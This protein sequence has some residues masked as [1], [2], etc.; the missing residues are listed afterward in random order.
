MTF[1]ERE[2]RDQVALIRL[3]RSV[4]NP[5]NL[6]LINELS[7]YII[8]T[9]SDRETAGV[10]LSSANDKF[11]SIGFD[12]PEL[13]K[14]EKDVFTEFYRAFNQ[15]CI[16][17]FTYPKP[18]IAA[19]TGHAVAGGCILALCCD[20]RFIAEG[21]KLIGLNEIKL[22]VPLPYPADR[23]LRQIVDDRSARRILDTGDFFRPEE[24]L[25]MG[26]VDEVLP[27][28][29]VVSRA[30]EKIESIRASSLDG[31]T[32]I[33]RNRIERVEAEIRSKLAVKEDVFIQMWYSAEAR[34]N[35]KAALEKF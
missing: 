30:C 15:L 18:L 20:Y 14:L 2:M 13:I 26:L 24:A 19:I 27:L 29:H 7:E 23:I 28:E 3:N 6:A 32:V 5:I 17:I 10:V 35:L 4:T 25:A 34:S 11:F 33:K 8:N 12:I 21:K 31:F 16:K 1:I 22:G 9:Q